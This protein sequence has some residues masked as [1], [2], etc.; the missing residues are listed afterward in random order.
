M[1]ACVINRSDEPLPFDLGFHPWIVRTP[2]TRLR[3][4]AETVLLESTDDLP[5]APNPLSSRC[6]LDFG[7]LRNL[8]G[9][10]IEVRACRL[11]YAPLT[12]SHA[13]ALFL[14][15]EEIRIRGPR[16]VNEMRRRCDCIAANAR[17]RSSAAIASTIA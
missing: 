6:E 14:C 12:S 4:V 16:L 15:L 7:T 3:A 11:V 1:R 5:P 13:R 8:L 9:R 2:D 10:W 17:G